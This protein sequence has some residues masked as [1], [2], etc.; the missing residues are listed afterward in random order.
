LRSS[1][2]WNPDGTPKEKPKYNLPR[3]AKVWPCEWPCNTF[4]R[5]AGNADFYHLANN[6]GIIPFLDEKCEQYLL[7]T[8]TFVQSFYFQPRR[9][10]PTVSFSLY[11]VPLEMMLDAFCQVCKLPNEG[12]PLEPRPRDMAEFIPTVSVGESRVF[13]EARVASLHF[14]VLCYYSLFAGRCLTGRWESGTLSAPDLA[15]FLHALHGDRT[16]SLGAMVPRRLHTNR[17]KGVIY[18]GIYASCLTKHF[19]IPIRHAEEELLPTKYLD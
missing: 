9:E 13:S 16:F 6:A 10:T 11:D 19:E 14:P 3:A 4:L 2:S 18:G 12:S 5:D 8:N 1:S 17:S 7:L 15:I